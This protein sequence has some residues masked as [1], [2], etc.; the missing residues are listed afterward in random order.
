M[1]INNF[2]DF[3]NES[4]RDYLKPKPED[5]VLKSVW[6]KL[7][8]MTPIQKLVYISRNDLDKIIPLDY[9]TT[10]IEEVIDDIKDK[11]LQN[12]IHTVF[13]NNLSRFFTIEK[14]KELIQDVLK[15]SND[16]SRHKNIIRVN[17]GWNFELYINANNLETTLVGVYAS[18]EVWNTIKKLI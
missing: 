17:N 4:V 2:D 18:K 15:I 7:E 10:L 9:M 6:I 1:I 12:K 8:E 3:M 11:H 16:I 13:D 5:E 14:K